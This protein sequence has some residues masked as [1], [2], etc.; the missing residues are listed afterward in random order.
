MKTKTTIAIPKEVK[1][2]LGEFGMKGESYSEIV[3]RL[4]KSAEERQLRD[5]LMDDE[6]TIPIGKALSKA[7]KRWQ[8]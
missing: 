3:L 6:E 8:K 5:I 1:E 4:L 7:K 2:R